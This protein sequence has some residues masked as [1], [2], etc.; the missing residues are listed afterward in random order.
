MKDN[1]ILTMTG[2]APRSRDT[3]ETASGRSTI[4]S[5]L[6]WLE[7]KA[8]LS[9]MSPTSTPF[10]RVNA[11]QASRSSR[12]RGNLKRRRISITIYFITRTNDSPVYR[13]SNADI[14]TNDT[15]RW[16]FFHRSDDNDLNTVVHYG[17]VDDTVI[18][19][20]VVYL[21]TTVVVSDRQRSLKINR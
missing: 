15:H 5:G 2:T 10:L 21:A 9:V 14:T 8:E 19:S 4:S 17:Q 20:H 12:Q 18:D 16:R 3:R 1:K 11:I 7:H 13:D 6:K